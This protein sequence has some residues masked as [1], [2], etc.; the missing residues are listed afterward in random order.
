MAKKP[1][2][3]AVPELISFAELARRRGCNR[4]TA[5]RAGKSVLA[6]AV[7]GREVDAAHPTVVKWLAGADPGP[8]ETPGK[9]GKGPVPTR[10]A[11]ARLTY[12]KR[13]AETTKLELAN[14]ERRG[15]LIERDR[16]R[17]HVFGVLDAQ[18]KRL[19][20]SK[21]TLVKRL[22]AL[23]VSGASQEEGERFVGDTLSSVLRVTR[24][25]VTR[26]L[27]RKRKKASDDA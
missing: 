21:G 22:Y 4:S 19:L 25:Q 2:K 13:L 27:R 14:A 3:T 18:N 15:D 7:V 24:D 8:T 12:R 17:T 26:N 23:A 16:V 5:T 10:E 11:F 20:Y 6:C 9:D 1:R